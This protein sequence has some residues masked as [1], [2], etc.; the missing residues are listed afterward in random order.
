MD[1]LEFIITA[2]FA[3]HLASKQEEE[4]R[5]RISDCRLRSEKKKI[6]RELE[7]LQDEIDEL[8]NEIENLKDEED[9]A[10]TASAEGGKPQ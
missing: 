4:Q 10:K 5:L 6:S 3:D 9:L 7:R 2:F 1:F 8:R